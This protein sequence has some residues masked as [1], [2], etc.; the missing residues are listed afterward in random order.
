MHVCG[1]VL[2][3]YLLPHKSNFDCYLGLGYPTQLHSPVLFQKGLQFGIPPVPIFY[4]GASNN[5]TLLTVPCTTLTN[6]GPVPVSTIPITSTNTN[7]LCLPRFVYIT[8]KACKEIL[9]LEFVN[10]VEL[11]PDAWQPPEDDNP[12]C[13]HQPHRVP[14]HG[15]VT[16]ILLWVECFS[17]MADILT[18]KY[19]K[20]APDLFTY[21]KNH[22]S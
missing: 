6:P 20:R 4:M 13:C 16:D 5:S 22:A 21:Q 7:R 19:P 2:H 11:V 1:D 17:I 15:P 9:D 14:K 18:T 3:C 10:T 8:S 12:K